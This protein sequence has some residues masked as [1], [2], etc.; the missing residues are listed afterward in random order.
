MAITLT[1]AAGREVQTQR[2]Q[3]SNG[4]GLRVGVRDVGCSD[5]GYSDEGKGL[6]VDQQPGAGSFVRP[7]ESVA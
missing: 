2:A 4:L 3:R 6:C 1:K 7:M 5:F